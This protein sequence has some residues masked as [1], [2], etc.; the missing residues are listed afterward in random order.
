MLTRLNRYVRPFELAFFALLE[1]SIT[2][3]GA[4]LHRVEQASQAVGLHLNAS[5]IKL[6][7][8]NSSSED[9][10][11]ALD[12]TVIEKVDDF[13]YLGSWTNT[14]YDIECRKAQAWRAL[15]ALT[16]V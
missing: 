8:I 9:P 14:S 2:S 6:M 3:A 1:D 11:R 4:F 13:K 10:L 15:H 16:K 7:G 5:K 12:N